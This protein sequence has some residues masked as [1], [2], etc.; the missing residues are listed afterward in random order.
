ME[1]LLQKQIL[2][3]QRAFGM[4]AILPAFAGHVPP[5]FVQRFPNANVSKLVGRGADALWFVCCWLSGLRSAALR[6]ALVKKQ[7]CRRLWGWD[8]GRI[9]CKASFCGHT[10]PPM[11]VTHWEGCACVR[12]N[13][14]LRESNV[15]AACSDPPVRVVWCQVWHPVY[16][17]TYFLDPMV[18]SL[19]CPFSIYT[20]TLQDPLFHV[21]GTLFLDMQRALYGTD[22]FYNA[23]PFN[24][25][26]WW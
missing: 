24:E 13:S 12:L 20:T 22:H 16:G 6:S 19:E 14:A 23:D 25:V 5:A 15:I 9:S 1:V 7:P 11:M 17:A 3:R 4:Q 18:S 2:R 10:P 26:T 21:V 8:C